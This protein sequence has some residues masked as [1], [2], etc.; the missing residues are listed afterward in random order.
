MIHYRKYIEKVRCYNT[1]FAIPLGENYENVINAWK[2][3]VKIVREY[4][5][6]AEY[7]I[8]ICIEMR[9]CKNR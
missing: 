9:V 5:N 3:I 6:K 4:K 1:E 2:S 8:N 7:P